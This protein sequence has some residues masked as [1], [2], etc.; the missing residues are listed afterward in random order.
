MRYKD[1]NDDQPKEWIIEVIENKVFNNVKIPIELKVTWK[2]DT[3]YFTWL[4]LKITEVH[5]NIPNNFL[6]N[7]Y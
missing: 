7:N 6:A 2:L 1:M 4:Q 3:E 5:Y